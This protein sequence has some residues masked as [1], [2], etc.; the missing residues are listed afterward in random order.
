MCDKLVF[1]HTGW[2][3][4]YQ[5]AD[6]ITD[7]GSFVNERGYGGEMWNFYD[8]HGSVYGFVETGRPDS[9]LDYWNHSRAICIERIGGRLGCSQRDNHT[10]GVTVVWTATRPEGGIYVVGWYRNATVFRN[11]QWDDSLQYRFH[12]QDGRVLPYNVR[13]KKADAHLLP[14]AERTIEVPR[15]RNGKGQSNIWYAENNP[16]FVREIRRFIA[17]NTGQTR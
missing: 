7:G 2:M 9:N 3:E 16:D 5:G 10:D 8:H 17:R 4:R 6:T 14:I 1:F 13:V 12:A 11:P 15:G